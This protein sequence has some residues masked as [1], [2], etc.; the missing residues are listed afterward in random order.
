MA[1]I[2]RPSTLVISSQT[3][4]GS[5]PP[6]EERFLRFDLNV[7]SDNEAERAV[8]AVTSLD[9]SYDLKGL[10]SH[11]LG[12]LTDPNPQ[13]HPVTT[14][15]SIVGTWFEN[16]NSSIAPFANASSFSVQQLNASDVKVRFTGTSFD[17]GPRGSPDYGTLLGAPGRLVSLKIPLGDGSLQSSTFSVLGAAGDVTLID[18]IGTEAS[19]SVQTQSAPNLV[20]ADQYVAPQLTSM[21]AKVGGVAASDGPD[22]GNAFDVRAGQTIEVTFT[23][24]KSIDPTTFGYSNLADLSSVG[25]LASL[26]PVSNSNNTSFKAILHPHDGHESWSADVTLQNLSNIRGTNGLELDTSNPS[27]PTTLSFAGDTLAP[28]VLTLTSGNS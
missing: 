18:E 20:Y 14:S 5:T 4:P 16:F 10:P 3:I 27:S 21:T 28:G 24:S 7:W 17:D 6:T 13:G 23:F 2:V 9:I 26:E 19:V 12:L 15:H 1:V 25:H 22:A 8:G 11:T